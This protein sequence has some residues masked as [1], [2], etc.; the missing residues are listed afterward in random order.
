LFRS[1]MNRLLP[2]GYDYMIKNRNYFPGWLSYLPFL[3]FCLLSVRI[4]FVSFYYACFIEALVLFPALLTVMSVAYRRPLWSLYGFI[5]TIPLV[6][7]LQGLGMMPNIPILSFAFAGLYLSWFSRRVLFERPTVLTKTAIEI[8]VDLLSSMIIISLSMIF[9]AGQ[10]N[11]LFQLLLFSPFQ[12]ADSSLYGI[13]AAYIILQ[14]LFLY[15]IICMEVTHIEQKYILYI[16]YIH[17]LTILVFSAI[18]FVFHIPPLDLKMGGAALYAPFNDKHSYGSYMSLLF[19]IVLYL[20][21]NRNSF[22]RLL[23]TILLLSIMC[24]IVLSWSRAT[25][26]AVLIVLLIYLLTIIKSWKISICT[27]FILTGLLICAN[28]FYA[29]HIIRSDNLYIK[30]LGGLIIFSA[31]AEDRNIKFRVIHWKRAARMVADHPITGSG[32]GSYYKL[33]PS[34]VGADDSPM[35]WGFREHTHNYYLQFAAEMGLPAL[36]VFLAIVFCTLRTGLSA[37]SKDKN[38]TGITFGIIS[39]LSAYLITCLAGH[40][41]L[42]TNQQLLFWSALALIPISAGP[43]EDK[44]LSSH[45]S[46]RWRNGVGVLF[47]LLLIAYGFRWWGAF[48][49]PASYEYGVYAQENWGEKKMRWTMQESRMRLKAAGSVLTFELLAG[50]RPVGAESLS[51]RLFLNALLY[52]EIHLQEGRP[53][54]FQ[55]PVPCKRGE[56]FEFRIVLNQTFNPHELGLSDDRRD[57]GVAISE[58]EFIEEIPKAGIGFYAPEI[59]TGEIPGWSREAPP[60]YRWTGKRAL[61]N[62]DSGFVKGITL[63]LLCAHPEVATFPVELRIM[64]N[65]RVIRDEMF[66]DREWRKIHIRQEELNDSEVLALNVSRTWN[67]MRDGVSGDNRDLGI[68]VALQLE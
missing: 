28:L 47:Y 42:L 44:C 48:N 33:S 22:N 21:Y 57:L 35:M 62:L 61:M 30:R 59:S 52:D 67:P 46:S 51:A 14:G 49:S 5:A 10:P 39:G 43:S 3:A 63:F 4:I 9:A 6:S 40:P 38:Q 64:G 19:F 11:Y 34:Y 2:V 58:L 54:R 12:A 68:A 27:I 29:S 17:I 41:L 55:Y 16:L 13:E 1:E 7:G 18:Q 15:R 20:A 24:L 60:E 66:E 45:C 25:W 31:V 32:V 53:E 26:F 56:L 65:G 36:V 37:I 50:P 8:L 23:N